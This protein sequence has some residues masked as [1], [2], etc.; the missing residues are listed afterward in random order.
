MSLDNRRIRVHRADLSERR[1]PWLRNADPGSIRGAGIKAQRLPCRRRKPQ[2]IG[3]RRKDRVLLRPVQAPLVVAQPVLMQAA[4][5]GHLYLLKAVLLKDRDDI[6][7]I[8]LGA[9]VKDVLACADPFVA[10]H[11]R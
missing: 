5:A 6:P 3:E 11:S 8:T 10:G 2:P 7:E 9:C 1:R 4:K